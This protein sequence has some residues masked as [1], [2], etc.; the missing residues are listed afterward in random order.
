MNEGTYVIDHKQSPP[1]TKLPKTSL[2]ACAGNGV[3]M[4][5]S[6]PYL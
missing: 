5:A 6:L 1:V 4:I 3:S 2:W